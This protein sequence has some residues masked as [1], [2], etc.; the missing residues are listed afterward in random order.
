MR[1]LLVKAL[2]DEHLY[3]IH[4]RELCAALRGM[5]VDAEILTVSND[6][7]DFL[8]K[9]VHPKCDAVISF[10]SFMAEALNVDSGSLYD[11]LGIQ[12]LGWQFDHPIYVYHQLATRIELR[13][14]IYPDRNHLR[15]LDAAGVHGRATVLLPGGVLPATPPKPYRARAIPIFVA[16]SWTGPPERSWEAMEDS[17]ARRLIAGTVERLVHDPEV[18]VID[19]FDQ[20][21]AELGYQG[22]RPDKD[23][24]ALLRMAL[25]YV[26]LSDRI[27]IVA[28]LA[29]AG[30]PMTICGPGWQ[31][32]LGN[33]PHVRFLERV[34]FDAVAG[35]YDD[36]QIAINLNAGN[37]GSE[38]AI[39]AALAGSCV[40]SD[41]GSAL[42]EEFTDGEQIAM[43]DRRNPAQ[44]AQLAGDL[45]ES[46]RGETLAAAGFARA[47]TSALWSHRCERVLELLA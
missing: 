20:T 46:G 5:G 25:T 45:L 31:D 18:S 10:S 36:A 12:F 43:F 44:A 2:S 40:V 28:A 4:A 35:L 11:L 3:S 38:R 15:F 33:P 9:I 23:V 47:S 16:A 41:F 32:Y 19:A 1:V 24:A 13:R 8:Q 6:R 22:L 17:P 37:G 27:D 34:P 14:S 21:K 30:L 29:A 39:Q 42:A 26:R 7:E